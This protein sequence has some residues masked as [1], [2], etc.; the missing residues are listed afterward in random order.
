MVNGEHRGFAHSTLLK[1]LTAAVAEACLAGPTGAPPLHWTPR[2]FR[3]VLPDRCHHERPASAYHPGHRRPQ[4]INTTMDYK[5]V[6]PD[7]A[8]QSHLA[9]LARRRACAPARSTAHR[10][11][12]SGKGS[13]ANSE[14]RKVS[15]GTRARAFGTPCSLSMSVCAARC[16]GLTRPSGHGWWR[17]AITSSP[18]SQ[19]LNAR[20]GSAKSKGDGRGA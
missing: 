17:Y 10:P 5:A 7:E 13:S 14:R 18:A 20:A 12:R 11:M 16:F 15:V 4:D 2:D 1:L 9:F 8:V 19:K 3:R 6:S